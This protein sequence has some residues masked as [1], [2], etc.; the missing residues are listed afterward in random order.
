MGV[1]ARFAIM[2]ALGKNGYECTAA[3]ANCLG[4]STCDKT[5][6]PCVSRK[7]SLHES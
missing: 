7:A 3:L 2:F 5:T 1:A 6:T 4:V